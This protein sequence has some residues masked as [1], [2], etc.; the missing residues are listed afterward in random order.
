MRPLA[1]TVLLTL[2]GLSS[3][4]ANDGPL[5]VFILS[6]QSNMQGHAHVSTFDVIGLDPKTVPM[7]EEMVDE[8]GQPRVLENVW[9]SSIGSSDEEKTGQLTAGYGAEKRGPKIG[10]EFTFGIY[11]E[12]QLNEPILIIKTAWGGKSLHTD[13]RPPSAGPYVL[14]EGNIKQLKAKGKD[15]EAEQAKRTEAS[16]HYYRLMME[17][18]NKVLGDIKRVYPEY[19]A[20]EGYEL[21][22]FVW[23]QGWNDMVDGGVYPNRYQPGGYD[24]YSELLAQFIKDVRKDLSAPELPFV[25]GVMGTGGPTKLYRKDRYKGVHQNFRDAMAA[26]ASLPE[27]KDNVAAVLTE[28]Y[29][30]MELEELRHKESEIKQ[31]IKEIRKKVKQGELSKQAGNEAE[32]QLYDE[33]FTERENTILKDGVSNFQFHYYGSAKIL[34]Q[35]G[36]AFAET[37]GE[38]MQK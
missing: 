13:F 22:G 9:I 36:K 24:A 26:P 23:F 32:Q 38:L 15:I 12:K 8:K 37:M 34:G 14:N 17:H 3:L 2:T 10:P 1:I 27:L 20:S 4:I 7:L 6:G 21:A 29:W 16:G 19:D 18:I 35:I 5:K 30:D 28:N 25:I 11:M 33:T 31:Q